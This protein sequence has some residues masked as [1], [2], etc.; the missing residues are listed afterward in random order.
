MKI[1]IKDRFSGAVLFEHEAEGNTLKLTVEAAVKV[2][3]NLGRADL[4]GAYLGEA[5]LPRASLGGADLRG[6]DLRGAYLGGADL[7]RASMGGADLG[8]AKISET[9][10]LLKDRPF[11]QLGPIGSRGDVLIAW[12]TDKGVFVRAGCFYGSLDDFR[13]AVEK[14]HGDS[15]HGKE[16]QAAMF[17]IEAHAAI[18][19]K[20]TP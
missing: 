18:W 3:A 16:Y 5:H 13:A 11:L 8:G 20:E 14:K 4:R 7:G 17:M 19:M 9:E 1:Q 15:D 12:L 6:A 10:T 2:R